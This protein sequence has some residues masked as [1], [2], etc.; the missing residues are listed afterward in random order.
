MRAYVERVHRGG[1]RWDMMPSLPGWGKRFAGCFGS[2][3]SGDVPFSL[4]SEQ[5]VKARAPRSARACGGN[6]PVARE[7]KLADNNKKCRDGARGA[8]FDALYQEQCWSALR[9]GRCGRR[10]IDGAPALLTGN[11]STRRCDRR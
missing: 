7:P 8:S 1:C 5:M 3:F 6:L 10:S 11:G 2:R 9:S 4:A